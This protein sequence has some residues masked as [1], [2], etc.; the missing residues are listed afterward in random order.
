MNKEIKFEEYLEE[1]CFEENPLVLD[2]NRPDFFDNWIGGLFTDD[3]IRYGNEFGV[4]VESQEKERIWD[5]VGKIACIENG[6]E[7]TLKREI[8]SSEIF[9][10]TKKSIK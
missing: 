8:A 3:L 10:G 9:P 7:D 1:V 2:D 6:C 5:L 4:M